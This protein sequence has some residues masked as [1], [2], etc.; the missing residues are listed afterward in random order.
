MPS[1][2]NVKI[3]IVGGNINIIADVAR[4]PISE[5]IAARLGIAIAS[6]TE[7]EEKLILSKNYELFKQ[8]YN[9]FIVTLK[10]IW[11]YQRI[12]CYSHVKTVKLMRK[13]ASPKF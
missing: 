6:E 9:L 13:M 2:P 8:F 4:A 12:H 11:N 3:S 7:A 10:F 1:K 5:I